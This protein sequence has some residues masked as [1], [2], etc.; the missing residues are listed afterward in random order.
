MQEL[1]SKSALFE[2]TGMIPVFD[3]S[4]AVI[5]SDVAISA[6]LQ[7]ELMAAIAPLEQIPEAEKDFHP[8]SD[9]K[10]LALVHPSLWP[11]VYGRTRVVRGRLITLENCF[12]E[13]EAVQIL[14]EPA[15]DETQ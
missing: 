2:E 12:E 9:G 6:H 8:R 1:R 14:Q 3:A 5:K 4:A 10:V 13:P 11:L 7:E 15:G